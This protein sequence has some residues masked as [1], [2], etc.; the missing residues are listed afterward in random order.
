MQKFHKCHQTITV[1]DAIIPIA[2]C[3]DNT[4]VVTLN[5]Y[6]QATILASQINNGSTDNCGP[7]TLSLNKYV[8]CT[9]VGVNN[10]ILTVTDSQ[11]NTATC[12]TKIRV[13]VLPL[14]VEHLGYNVQTKQQ[15]MP[16]ILSR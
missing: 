5:S 14:I 6:R 7:I 16:P 9:D 10:C 15:L 11:G 3:I 2:R 12:A 8:Y 4:L 1:N 13:D